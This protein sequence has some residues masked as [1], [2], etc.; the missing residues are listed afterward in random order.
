MNP[1]INQITYNFRRYSNTNNINNSHI[2]N[3]LQIKKIL[4]YS[5]IQVAMIVNNFNMQQHQKKTERLGEVFDLSSIA[6][7]F[8][9]SDSIFS[10]Y[11]LLTNRPEMFPDA[12]P[13][14]GSCY[15]ARLACCCVD[16]AIVSA[17]P[18]SRNYPV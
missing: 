9:S 12:T 5:D 7:L 13:A 16:I 15:C 11:S 14:T 2:L 18:A 6:V 3:S 4:I 8:F 1:F 17:H 10:N